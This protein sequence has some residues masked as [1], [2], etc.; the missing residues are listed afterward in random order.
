MLFRSI[1]TSLSLLLLSA[2][3]AWADDGATAVKRAILRAGPDK[4]STSISTIPPG[5]A[6]EIIGSEPPFLQVRVPS[7]KIGW[8]ADHLV[9]LPTATAGEATPPATQLPPPASAPVATTSSTAE[10]APPSAPPAPP[11]AAAT[12]ADTSPPLASPTP[13]APLALLLTGGLL[14]F[15]GG[16]AYRERYYRKRLHGLRV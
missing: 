7:G 3:P 13:W 2:S 8:V 14:G 10:A 1:V 5:T 16:Y 15:A 4:A 12:T 6:L 9:K 11:P